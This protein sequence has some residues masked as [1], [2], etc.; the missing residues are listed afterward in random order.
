MDT[1]PNPLDEPFGESFADWLATR[2]PIGRPAPEITPVHED[3][4]PVRFPT[5]HQQAPMRPDTAYAS[6]VIER[7]HAHKVLRIHKLHHGPWHHPEDI[8]AALSIPC[9]LGCRD[10]RVHPHQPHTATL[11]LHTD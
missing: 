6:Q 7:G 8:L 1:Q 3:G 4:Q 2:E 10:F 5:Q 9:P 11:I